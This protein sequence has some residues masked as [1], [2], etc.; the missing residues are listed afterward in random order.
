MLMHCAE[1]QKHSRYLSA[2]LLSRKP[3]LGFNV[4]AFLREKLPQYEIDLEYMF[5]VRQE[6][7][8]CK[9]GIGRNYAY[10]SDHCNKILISIFLAT[11]EDFYEKVLQNKINSTTTSES[12]N[13]INLVTA[14]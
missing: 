14:D 1:K 11:M 2:L 3:N 8:D 9:E 10:V 13:N 7:E 12:S 4:K 5:E 6:P